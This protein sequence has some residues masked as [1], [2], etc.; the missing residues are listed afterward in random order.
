[1]KEDSTMATRDE[2]A[3]PPQV[4]TPTSDGLVPHPGTRAGKVL[5]DDATWV[6]PGGAQGPAGPT[7]PAGPA[8]PAGAQ[9]PAGAAGPAGPA[10]PV[11]E[12]PNDGQMYAR[13]S[14][15]W[16]VISST[17]PPQPQPPSDTVDARNFSPDGT[18]AGTAADPWPGVAIVNALASLPQPAGGKVFVANG[19]WSITQ[20]HTI[21]L[22]NI[23]LEGE[24]L[25]A[26][27][28]FVNPDGQFWFGST[29]AAR[30]GLS[31]S[32][33]TFNA[34]G[35]THDHSVLRIT[36]TRNS[37]FTGNTILGTDNSGRPA[38]IWEG[39]MN[40]KFDGNQCYGAPAGGDNCFQLQALGSSYGSTDSDWTV[41]NNTF[42]SCGPMF[43]G[44]NNLLLH[45]NSMTNTEM[46][47]FIDNKM[48]S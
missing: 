15:K 45:H 1:M 31:L 14:G 42:D 33:L 5:R 40:N 39:G 19:I 30:V 26:E 18:H 12:A 6:T 36:N 10:G 8:G 21:N 9:G 44:L 4:F 48:C 3:P 35:I 34:N 2:R 24:S 38:L 28:R 7:G 41:T 16:V 25:D 32:K 11:G 46:N 43:I 27:L 47:N 22:D 17:A 20:A 37:F 23:A 29:F 13:Q